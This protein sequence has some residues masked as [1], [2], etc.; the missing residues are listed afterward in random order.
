MFAPLDEVAYAAV[1]DAGFLSDA[2]MVMGLQVGGE[3]VAFP[4]R[5]LA[6]HHLVNTEIG[7]EPLVATY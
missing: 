5:Q 7:G 1:A 4:V 3:S 2:E 6:Y